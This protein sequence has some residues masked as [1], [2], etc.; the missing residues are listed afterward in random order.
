MVIEQLSPEQAA[1]IR[2]D[3]QSKYKK[4]A[5]SPEGLFQ[6]PIGREGA[7]SLGYNPAWYDFAPAGAI[8]RFVGV[9]NPFKIR[10]PK[11]GDCVLDAGCGC[12]FDTFLAAHMA[13]PSGKAIGVDL[14]SEMLTV[15]RSAAEIFKGGNVEFREGSLEK[16]PFQDGFF[17]LAISN[18]VLNLVPDKRAAFTEIARVL[19]PGGVL[20]AADLL[21]VEEIPPEVLA[22][23][24]AWST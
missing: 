13:G 1:K 15:A 21:V 19:R 16:L 2:S 7:L 3:V 24:D 6:Y 10:T 12:G 23:T 5:I 22:N 20:V 8:D 4:V 17:D 11:P 9:G 18:G 14:T